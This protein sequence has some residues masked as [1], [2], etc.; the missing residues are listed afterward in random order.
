MGGYTLH[1]TDMLAWEVVRGGYAFTL[2]T[3][4]HDQLINDFGVS[5][6]K[7][8]VLEWMVSSALMVT[9]FYGKLSFV[10]SSVLHTELFV[11]VGVALGSFKAESTLYK[12]GPEVG[13]GLRFFLSEHWSIRFEGR[14]YYLIDAHSTH[15]V[16]VSLGLALSLGGTD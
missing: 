12:P 8:E 10:N 7:F 16:D 2:N 15:V 9:P 13:L 5:E 4:L 14:Y 6:T 1:F 11:L 3:A